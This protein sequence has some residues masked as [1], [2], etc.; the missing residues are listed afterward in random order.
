[1]LQTTTKSPENNVNMV[2]TEDDSLNGFNHQLLIHGLQFEK[3]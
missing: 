1:M 3:H 2:Q